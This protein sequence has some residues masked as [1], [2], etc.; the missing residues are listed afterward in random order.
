MITTKIKYK[1]V[2]VELKYML[3]YVYLD[4][5][6]TES[7]KHKLSRVLHNNVS[8][9]SQILMKSRDINHISKQSSCKRPKI[10]FKDVI[11]LTKSTV[12]SEQ[13]ITIQKTT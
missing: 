9:Y 7:F 4:R 11:N 8:K 2:V 3:K 10:R 13:K 1:K 12:N 5:K 6:E